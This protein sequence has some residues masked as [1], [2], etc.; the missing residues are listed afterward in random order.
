TQALEPIRRRIESA[1]DLDSV[2]RV[3]KAIAAARI[4]Q[5]ERAVESLTEYSR[6]IEAGLQV[7]LR[8]QPQDIAAE[9]SASRHW[10]IIVF[11]SDQ[12]MCGPFNEQV[13]TFLLEH[14]GALAGAEEART[15]L[16]VG[17][18]LVGRLEDA[19]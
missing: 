11:G 7:V 5:C 2:V 18:R 8:N 17:S 13:A 19:G 9:P 6:T 15:I 12:G 3:M 10:G 4:R 1:Q 14:I 16:V